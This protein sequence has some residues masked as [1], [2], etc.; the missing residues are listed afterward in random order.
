[1]VQ[2][3]LSS[4]DTADR[5]ARI[6]RVAALLDSRFRV[7]VIGVRVGWDSILGVIPGIG[8][9]VTTVPAGWMIWQGYQMGARKRTLARMGLNAGID[10]IVGG[11]PIIGDLFDVAFKSHKKNLALLQSDM[12]RRVIHA[13]SE[14]VA[15]G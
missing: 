13:S 6:A 1:M 5:L 11:V 9:A 14:E 3:S 7:P 15:H 8:D 12:Q 4:A 2:T 10:L